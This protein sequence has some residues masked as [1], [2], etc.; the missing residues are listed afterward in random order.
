MRLWHVVKRYLL[1]DSTGVTQCNGPIVTVYRCTST[2]ERHQEK[3][4]D[5][6]VLRGKKRDPNLTRLGQKLFLRAEGPSP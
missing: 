3:S 6:L 5:L 2:V 4:R 1:A